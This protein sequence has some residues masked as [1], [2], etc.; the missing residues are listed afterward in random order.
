MWGIIIHPQY[1]IIDNVRNIV[2]IFM[3]VL[4]VILGYT[5]AD[6][7]HTFHSF[8]RPQVICCY[9]LCYNGKFE[10]SQSTQ[11]YW[12]EVSVYTPSIL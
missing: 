8:F 11:N 10:L 2:C 12:L 3:Y 1:T 4:T 5:V 7:N 9:L 6:R